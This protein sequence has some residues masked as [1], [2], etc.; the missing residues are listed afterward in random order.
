MD[1]AS[2]ELLRHL[3]GQVSTRPW[4]VCATRRPVEGGFSAADGVPPIPAMTIQLQPLDEEASQAADRRGRRAG[5]ASARGDGDRR[6]RRRQPALPAGARRLLRRARGGGAARERRGSR[7]HADRQ[8]RSP[9]TGRS[10]ATPR[11]SGRASAPSSSPTCWPTTPKPPPTRRR[12]TGWA[13]SSS[14]TR[15][16]R[17]PSASATPSSATPPTRGSPTSDAASCTPRSARRTSGSKARDAASSPSCSR[18]T[19]STRA[20]PRR[21]TAT[22]SSPASARRRSSRTSRRRSSTGARSTS[23]RSSSSIPAELARVWEAVGDVS[24]LAGLYADAEEAY[25]AGARARRQHPRLL[26]KEGVIRERFG[27]YAEALRWYN[28]GL[29]S[30][31]GL[32]P[33]EQARMRSELGARL[34][35]RPRPPGRVRRRCRLV[36]ARRRGGRHRS[37]TCRRWRTPTT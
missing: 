25:A 23:R 1:E 12:G 37:T 21:A 30:L 19:S 22:R 20:T 6:P 9:A 32:E 15:T 18:C 11:C 13:S 29:R 36:Q 5:P 28:R 2:A 10:C 8:A 16:R 31:D 7:R 14:A 26:L 33:D 35:G 27:R 34:R 17:A 3:G 4:L 24:E